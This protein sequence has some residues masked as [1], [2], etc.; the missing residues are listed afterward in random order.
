MPSASGSVACF[1]APRTP[2]Q[3]QPLDYLKVP[4]E[5]GQLRGFRGPF[6]TVVP[7]PLDNVE[8]AP[9]RSHGTRV[10][11]PRAPFHTTAPLKDL[12]VSFLSR[13]GA[14]VFIPGAAAF[15]GALQESQ[16]PQGGDVSAHLSLQRLAALEALPQLR[17]RCVRRHG[18]GVRW[19][20]SPSGQPASGDPREEEML[21]GVDK[22]YQAI[23]YVGLCH[24]VRHGTTAAPARGCVLAG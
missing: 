4:L 9:S 15:S 7:T 22:L 5:G 6:A 18:A 17:R 24:R 2:V 23:D 1:E 16:L 3:L 14:C 21:L 10:G 13:V 20:L 11:I 8:K 12:E 19:A